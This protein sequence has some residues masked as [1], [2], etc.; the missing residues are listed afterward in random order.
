[1]A[2]LL[3]MCVDRRVLVALGALG[4]AIW[5]YSPQLIV[6]AVPTLLLLVCPLS[7]IVMAWSMRGSMP[8]NSSTDPTARLA[9]LERQQTRVSEEIAGVRAQLARNVPA[10][11]EDR[12]ES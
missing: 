1:M 7:M 9:D 6:A 11:S 10:R 2:R 4:V 3:A 5:L 12:A 8:M